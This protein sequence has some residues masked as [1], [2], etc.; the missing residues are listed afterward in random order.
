MSVI[1]ARA[2]VTT[3]AL[4]AVVTAVLA[5]AFRRDPAGCALAVLILSSVSVPLVGAAAVRAQPRNATGWI[6]LVTGVTIPLAAAAYLYAHAAYAGASLPAPQWAAWLDA[7]PWTPA[8]TL[9]PVLGLL[10]F[11]TGR[12]PSAGWRPVLAAAFA[13]LAAQLASALFEPDLLD[14]P[15]RANPTALGGP[16]GT[17]AGALGA[18]IVCVPVLATV[19]AWSVHW[20]WRRAAPGTPLSTILRLVTPAAWL[21]AA[22]WW[23]CGAVILVTGDSDDALVP[24]LLG[25]LALAAAAWLA[26]RRYRL[27]DA[28]QV[29]SQTLVYA[30]LSIVVLGV[31]A[32]MAVSVGAVAV[33]AV[34]QPVAVLA[35]IAVALPVRDALRRWATRL[36][37]GDRDDP[38]SALMRLGRRLEGAAAPDDIV[39]AVAATIRA[40]LR[41]EYVTVRIGETEVT[42]GTRRDGAGHLIPLVFAGETIG[43]LSTGRADGRPFGPAEQRLLDEVAR[44][45]AAAGHAVALTRDVRRS[46]EQLVTAAEEERRRLR[47]DLHD[48]LGAGLAGIVLGLQRARGNVAGDPAAATAQLDALTAQTQAA[49]AEVRRLVE[50]LRPAALDELGLIG[51]L[52]ERAGAFGSIAVTGPAEPPALPAAVEVAAYRIAVEAMTNISRHAR[53]SSAAVRITVDRA[54]HLEIADDGDGLP[55]GFRAGVGISSMRER[56][57]EL[58]GACVIEAA[59][60]RGTTVR[61]TIPLDI[62]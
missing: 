42:A 27:F 18:T 58:G 54:L 50:G 61:A 24:E 46:R 13:V 52:T 55:D 20:R 3:A 40:A 41:L 60:P 47:R 25:I 17:A 19:G 1:A 32:A 35:A 56:A 7:W 4:L 11:P 23:S 12:P 9:V 37:Y 51:A 29:L 45:V 49:I 8:L 10:L 22:S 31:Y 44:Q 30:S 21:I 36:V 28:R 59:S 33:A 6:L 57:A 62:R 43:V 26:I 15:H 34:S 38:Y 53:A 48:G 5:A 14:F 39:P 16:A 2:A